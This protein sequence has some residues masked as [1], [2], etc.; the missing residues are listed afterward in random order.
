MTTLKNAIVHK[1]YTD[2]NDIILNIISPTDKIENGDWYIDTFTD[3]LMF[4]NVNSDHNIYTDCYKV[5]SS[6]NKKLNLPTP[7]ISFINRYLNLDSTFDKFVVEYNND[8]LK[9]SNNEIFIR[10]VN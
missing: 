9:V 7:S 6:T 2:S 8:T 1:V 5:I 4:A 3:T 10:E